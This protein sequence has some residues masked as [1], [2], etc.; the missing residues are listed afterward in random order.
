MMALPCIILAIAATSGSVSG[1][2]QV[3]VVRSAGSAVGSLFRGW[4]SISYSSPSSIRDDDE[5]LCLFSV[6]GTDA[7]GNE[8]IA[9]L[10]EMLPGSL[11]DGQLVAVRPEMLFAKPSP[12]T[13]KSAMVSPSTLVRFSLFRAVR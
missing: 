7:A 9:V 8:V 12:P 4:G 1:L 13:L 6:S 10:D 2:V 11:G 3:R 5:T